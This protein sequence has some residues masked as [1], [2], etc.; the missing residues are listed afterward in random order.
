MGDIRAGHLDVEVA[1]GRRISWEVPFSEVS[2]GRFENLR[3]DNVSSLLV[4]FC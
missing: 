1:I 4:V 3:Q 2:S